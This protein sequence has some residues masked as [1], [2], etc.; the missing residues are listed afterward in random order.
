MVNE[1]L[2]Y[3][4]EKRGL[5]ATYKSGFRKQRNTIDPVICLRHEIR[6]AHRNK[7]TLAALFLD[8]EKAYDMFWKEGLL[9]EMHMMEENCLIELKTLYTDELFR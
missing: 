4:L 7:K 9:I 3:S 8:V 6:K 2:V 5:M 1:R